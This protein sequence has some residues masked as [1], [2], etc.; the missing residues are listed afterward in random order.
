MNS[1][2]P[3]LDELHVTR[4]KLLA[5]AGGDLHRYI[6]ESRERALASGRPIAKQTERTRRS[7]IA[8]TLGIPAT[9]HQNR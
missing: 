1:T 8:V 9:E 5:E 6:D 7:E 2:N 4:E 3:I